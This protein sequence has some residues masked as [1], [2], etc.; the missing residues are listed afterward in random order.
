MELGVRMVAKQQ[1]LWLVG[2]T[3]VAVMLVAP[4]A[5]AE[6]KARNGE[7][8]SA[9]SSY[10]PATSHFRSDQEYPATTID[11]WLNQIAQ[12]AAVT[13]TGIQ[14]EPTDI[15][16]EIILETAAGQPSEPS[17]SVVGNALIVEIPNAVLAL[18]G[19]EFQQANPA[20][21]IA[22]VAVTALANNR[23]RVAV[24]G[25]EAAPTAEV[26]ITAQ[27]LVL[28][29]ASGTETADDAEDAIQV[30]VTGE[31]E[32]GYQVERATTA[33]RT[34]TPILNIPQS[35]Q[36][37]PRQVI[38]DQ[39]A[40][41][42][43]EVLRNVSGI[44]VNASPL[45]IFSDDI[46]IRGIT[47]GRD[48]YRN[49]IRNFFG[50]F[51]LGQETANIERV[52]VL[53]GPASILYGQA[54]PGGVVNLITRSPLN[55][56]YYAVDMTVGNYNFYRPT[57]DLSGP[58]N[59]AGTILYRFNAAYQYSESFVDTFDA[60][61]FFIAPTL[62]IQLSEN[63]TLTID[64]EYL[65]DSRPNYTGLPA[66]GTVL[67]NP[68]GDVPI[69][70]FLGDED[71]RDRVVGNVGYR[72]EHNFNEA[73]S[74]R[75]SF[76]YEFLGVNEDAI[77]VN[78]L[79]DDNRTVSRGAFRTRGDAQ[80]YALQTDVLGE[81]STGNV[82]H[83]LLFGLELRRTDQDFRGGGSPPVPD[84]D[85]FDPEYGNFDLE[86]VNERGAKSTQSVIAGYV[87]DLISIGE[88]FTILLGARYDWVEQTTNNRD[89]NQEFYQRDTALTPRVGIVYQPIEPLSLY[90]SY[91]RSFAP[92]F[93]ADF[94]NADGSPFEPTEGE[95]VEIG[96]K[97]ELFDNRLI[98]TLAAY[99]LTR[100]N[101]VTPDPQRPGFSLQIG[102]ERSRGIE[103][104][105]IGEPLPGLSLIASYAY[106]DAEIT[107]DNSGNEGNR[108]NNVPEHSGSLWAT[109]TIQAGTLQGLGFGLGAFIVG[110][111]EGDLGN[112]FQ[113]PGYIRTDA[114]LFY[115]RENWDIALNIKNLFDVEYYESASFRDGVYPG[116]PFTILGTVSVRF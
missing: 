28:S 36:V 27:G 18:E 115:R 70:R 61:R 56:P 41:Q 21:G 3:G 74:I 79:L 81:V 52:E 54:E 89:A 1:W 22:L 2:L 105:L 83:Q 98:A 34:D 14:L 8:R 88:A 53:K 109:Y 72:L 17:S 104:D 30:V 40:T 86:F 69:S 6:E 108:P 33:T 50:G 76:R 57:L 96:V 112:T 4:V 29:V 106:T 95:Q 84:I 15:G 87:Q 101:I 90:A 107:K 73:W 39:A 45:T 97:A 5:G 116:A 103:F 114:A 110:E 12:T 113:L 62:Q 37:V 55:E 51:N 60:E 7:G 63:T 58:L 68:L 10:S 78:A 94:R 46:R 44:A 35:I 80:N 48:Y 99:D 100:Q 20:E 31:Q 9:S 65:D 111:R 67:E 26:R 92:S 32:R 91:S 16:V 66:L 49:G 75:N 102:E 13:I 64:G 47:A 77:F 24:T 42:V 23:V 11:E 43:T 38:E 25:L 19:D 93:G 82:E 85:L 71:R 59:A